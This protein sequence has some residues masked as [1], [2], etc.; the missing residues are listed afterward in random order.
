[1]FGSIAVGHI[2]EDYLTGFVR[3]ILEISVNSFLSHSL[4]NISPHYQMMVRFAFQDNAV[5]QI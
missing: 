3:R 4:L 5:Q 1:M 2:R